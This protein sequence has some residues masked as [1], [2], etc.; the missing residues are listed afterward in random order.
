MGSGTSWPA[1]VPHLGQYEPQSEQHQHDPKE[2]DLKKNGHSVKIISSKKTKKTTTNKLLYKP[3][4]EKAYRQD[5]LVL[6]NLQL[7]NTGWVCRLQHSDS[8]NVAV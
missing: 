4:K 7:S 3:K 8:Q 5:N 1:S 2:I 6:S